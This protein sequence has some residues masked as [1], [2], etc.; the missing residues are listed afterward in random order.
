M[1]VIHTRVLQKLEDARVILEEVLK[2]LAYNRN[3]G[4]N[5]E[6]VGKRLV[7]Y[8]EGIFVF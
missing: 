2:G 7:F 1:Y 4:N 8:E 5:I 3:T 6:G